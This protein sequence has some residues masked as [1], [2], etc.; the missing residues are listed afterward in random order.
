MPVDVSRTSRER[1][2]YDT[3]VTTEIDCIRVNPTRDLDIHSNVYTREGIKATLGN[4]VSGQ[5]NVELQN[6]YQ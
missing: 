2:E 3:P 5:S 6:P 4:G 1:K